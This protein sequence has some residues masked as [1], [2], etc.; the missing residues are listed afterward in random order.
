MIGRS[1]TYGSAKSSWKSVADGCYDWE[2][3]QYTQL[4]SGGWV[5]ASSALVEYALDP[6]NF[7]NADNIFI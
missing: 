7:L 5:Q 6:R 3:G 4:D 2:S 1:L